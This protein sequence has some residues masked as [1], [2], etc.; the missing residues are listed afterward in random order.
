MSEIAD[1]L[2]FT[3]T[4][5]LLQVHWFWMLVALGLGVWVGWFTAGEPASPP[6]EEEQP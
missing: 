4:L 2:T 5:F 1:A 3:G 6:P